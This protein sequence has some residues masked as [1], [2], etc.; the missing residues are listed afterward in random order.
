MGKKYQQVNDT[1]RR[2][3][4]NMQKV[5][6]T[7]S[8]IMEITERSSKTVNNVL[9]QSQ[10]KPSKP[11]K[12]DSTKK[13]GR[14]SNKTKTLLSVLENPKLP[15][16][17]K[18]C[19]ADF[20]AVVKAMDKLQKKAKGGK[21]VTMAMA[22]AEAG[23][24]A[25]DRVCKDAFHANDVTFTKLKE[26]QILQPGDEKLRLEFA[27]LRKGRSAEAWVNRPHAVIDM[28]A[29][30]I[31]TEGKGRNYAARRSC[32]GA[33]QLRGAAPKPWLIKPNAK[34]KLPAKGT[35]VGAAVVKGKI[36]MWEYI[37]GRWNAEKAAAMYRGPLAAAMGRAFPDLK[38]KPNAKW[39][40]LEDNDPCFKSRAAMN[41]KAVA[42]IITDDLPP[43]S[44]DMNVLDYSLWHLIN[45][46]MR[47]QEQGFR[48]NFK[49]TAEA[50]KAR[51]RKTALGL[52]A[53]KVTK[54]VKDM[55]IR[56]QKAIE[57]EGGLFEK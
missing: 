45:M 28:K 2:L 55:K 53:A 36:R 3:I 14:R 43:R 12:K 48:A 31:F 23:V 41:A 9:G 5:G 50:F 26:H 32:R 16:G 6:L 39:V 24:T 11:I 13:K 20:T 8:K 18:L 47:K 7:W 56:M 51:L 33:Y 35:M 19:R 38:N 54:A 27:N 37:E 22:R 21:E 57:Q 46:E 44:P 42:G 4:K 30:Q 1:E 49:E 40:V 17:G 52:P 29:F 10:A 25:S 34:M 15:P